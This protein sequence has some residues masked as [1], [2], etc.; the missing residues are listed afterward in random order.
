MKIVGFFKHIAFRSVSKIMDALFCAAPLENKVVF[1]AYSGARYDCNPRAVSE[2]LH[3]LYP[4]VKQ[5]WLMKDPDSIKLPDYVHVVRYGSFS[6]FKE[7]KTAK[8]WVDNGTKS[9]WINKRK[10]QFFLETWHGGLGFKKMSTEYKQYKLSD[11]LRDRHSLSMTDCFLTDSRWTTDL[12][13]RLYPYYKGKFW[14]C[15]YP[16]TDILYNKE[17]VD[18]VNVQIREEYGIP[19]DSLVVL[20]APTYRL[21]NDPQH[22]KIDFE[23]VIKAVETHYQKKVYFFVK[24][25]HWSERLENSICEYTDKVI[26]LTHYPHMQKLYM[27][28]D[29]F[30]TD[31]SSGIFEYSILRKPALLYADDLEQYCQEE[32]GLYFDL[33]KTPF[34]FAE[35]QDDLI[36]NLTNI[37]DKAYIV[38]LDEFYTATGFIDTSESSKSVCDAIAAFLAKDE[39]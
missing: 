10:G 29:Y 18:T 21:D 11:I 12:Y 38:K 33:H 4:E 28:A 22:F 9:Q 36:H 14:E 32:R 23:R 6:M 25:H 7:L 35:T 13:S 3:L 24:L 30:I 26:N 16:R 1:T 17:T 37:D 27:V 20:Y 15:G 2:K 5:T 39:E 19:L 8:V 34:P 31:Y